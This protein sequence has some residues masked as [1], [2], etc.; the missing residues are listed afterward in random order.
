MSLP[1]F[2]T[3]NV[4]MYLDSIKSDGSAYSSLANDLSSNF[5]NAFQTRF[6]VNPFQVNVINMSTPQQ[7]QSVVD[8]VSVL[9]DTLN[10]DPNCNE[11]L[12]LAGGIAESNP[13]GPPVAIKYKVKVEIEVDVNSG[14]T[15]AKGSF[16]VEY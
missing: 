15:T 12:G 6:A 8:A 4:N 5:L 10:N 3:A 1:N 9:S 7:K 16:E 2:N 13:T 14:T 11:V